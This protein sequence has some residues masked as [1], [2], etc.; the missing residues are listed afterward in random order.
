MKL[1]LKKEDDSRSF[2]NAI[3][4]QDEQAALSIFL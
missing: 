2:L 4:L 1:D 3:D